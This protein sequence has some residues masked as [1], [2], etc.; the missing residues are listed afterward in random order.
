MGT[1]PLYFPGCFDSKLKNSFF[2]ECFINIKKL[3]G[4]VVKTL[5]S[6]VRQ[7]RV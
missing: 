1:Q 6:G 7:I 4:T 5:A 3:N 2:K